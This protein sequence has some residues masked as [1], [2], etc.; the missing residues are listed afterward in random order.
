M[1][2]NWVVKDRAKRIVRRVCF[3]KLI[4]LSYS[5]RHFFT[6]QDTNPVVGSSTYRVEMNVLRVDLSTLARA[7]PVLPCSC[8]FER[9]VAEKQPGI[10][11]TLDVRFSRCGKVGTNDSVP[12]NSLRELHALF[13]PPY[14]IPQSGSRFD[15]DLD[16]HLPIIRRT[17]RNANT[18]HLSVRIQIYA[19]PSSSSVS[20]P[21]RAFIV[22]PCQKR[23][24]LINGHTWV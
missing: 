20:M 23:M 9:Q 24:G 8:R 15:P 7:C 13:I 18:P 22:S 21:L 10:E 16:A 2:V 6:P 19:S 3:R 12:G 4:I 14:T 5:N 17:N 11:S 1:Q